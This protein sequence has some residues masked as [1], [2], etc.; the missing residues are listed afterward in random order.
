MQHGGACHVLI[1]VP[2]SFNHLEGQHLTIN[3]EKIALCDVQISES[4]QRMVSDH[5]GIIILVQDALHLV[6]ILGSH[7][8][9]NSMQRIAHSNEGLPAR[10]AAPVS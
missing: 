2:P 3:S 4:Y 8:G 10:H 7:D 5:P 9:H 1:A 6:C